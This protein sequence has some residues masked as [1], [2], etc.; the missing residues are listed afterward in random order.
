M[1]SL[2]NCVFQ[3]SRISKPK[4]QGCK[5]LCIGRNLAK[6]QMVHIMYEERTI[7]SLVR[8]VQVPSIKFAGDRL[9]FDPLI[10]LRPTDRDYVHRVI[11]FTDL[12]HLF[13]SPS[14]LSPSDFR[15]RRGQP[16]L[17]LLPPRRINGADKGRLHYLRRENPLPWRRL[18]E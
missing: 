10:G 8:T 11:S 3:E 13:S 2:P 16:V 6:N 17:L 4:I 15:C 7:H 9:I 12:S 5:N 1:Q 14:S 18:N